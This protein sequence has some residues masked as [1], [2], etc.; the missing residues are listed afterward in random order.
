MTLDEIFSLWEKDSVIDRT[1]LTGASL[2]TPK[3]HHKY[4]RIHSKENLLLKKMEQDFNVLFKIKTEYYLG[5][6]DFETI[7]EKGWEPNP[8]K[9]L[10]AELPTYIKADTDIIKSN[11]T[12]AMQR[13]KVSVLE[14]IIK[15]ITNRGFA[16]K[17]AIDYIKF[18]AGE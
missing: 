1:E 5:T 14:S 16:I 6:L 13:E 2:D 10:K 4:L 18:Q 17:S 7:K 12:I 15:T 9:I 3:L 11:L 8:L